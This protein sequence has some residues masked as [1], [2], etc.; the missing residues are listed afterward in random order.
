M[1]AHSTYD[2]VFKQISDSQ[3]SAV[4]TLIRNT[5]KNVLRE[6]Y[7]ETND[8]LRDNRIL[9][10]ETYDVV[11]VDEIAD[12]ACAIIKLAP[13]SEF[14]ISGMVDY[15]ENSGEMQDFRIH[16]ADKVLKTE[17]SDWFS[18]MYADDCD[19]Y[20]EYLE[21]YGEYEPHLSEEQF[22]KWQEGRMFFA[23]EDEEDSVVEDVPLSYCELTE[24]DDEGNAIREA[25][26]FDDDGNPVWE[27]FPVEESD[28]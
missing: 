2:I 3:L 17:F 11:D 8:V 14:T 28:E 24:F 15:S 6:L 27:D 5:F 9:I 10:D 21:D 7:I 13:D 25:T 20:E 19:T 16:Y 23:L 4:A 22:K 18:C 12:F 26:V 1:H